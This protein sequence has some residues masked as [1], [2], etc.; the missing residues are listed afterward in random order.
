LKRATFA[1]AVPRLARGR[2]ALNASLPFAALEARFLAGPGPQI[3]V[4]DGFL[5]TE[6]LRLV[7]RFCREATVWFDVKVSENPR[8]GGGYLGAYAANGFNAD[9]LLQLEEEMRARFPAL[10]GDRALENMWSYK[11]SDGGTRAATRAGG[12]DEGII[13]HA[14]DSALNLNFWVTENEANEDPSS[15][16]LR[17][18]TKPAPLSWGFEKF[19]SFG[20]SAEADAFFADSEVVTVPY[21][22]NRAVI[23]N[24]N[25]FHQTDRFS[26]K[27]GYKNR[28]INVTFLF[29][30]RGETPVSASV[31]K[32]LHRQN[33]QAMATRARAKAACR[34]CHRQSK[35]WCH[36]PEKGCKGTCVDNAVGQC[37]CGSS[38]HVVGLQAALKNRDVRKMLMSKGSLVQMGC[39][40][41]YPMMRGST[42][43]PGS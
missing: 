36:A 38:A 1:P 3:L 19:N 4:V 39:A 32:Q 13:R 2:A 20:T 15:G 33:K 27:K 43:Y 24:G 34:A 35:G 8:V 6:A 30:K 10:I 14:D 40:G 11:Y 7:R 25:Y 37:A 41:D 42:F 21:R 17:V 26:F 23:F 12:P 5:S 29:G 31:D 18:W 9:L 16:G 28:R 22:E